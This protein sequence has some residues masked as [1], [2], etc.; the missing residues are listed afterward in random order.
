MQEI[1]KLNEYYQKDFQLS[2]FATKNQVEVDL[3]LSKGR[4]HILLEIKS[5]EKIDEAEV[6]KL[7]RIATNFP[8]ERSVYYISRDPGRYKIQ[9]VLCVHWQ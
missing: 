9:S 4:N 1:Y 3:I 7:Q 5:G 8:R 6:L 2:F